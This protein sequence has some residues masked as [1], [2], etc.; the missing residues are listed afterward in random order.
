VVQCDMQMCV[1]QLLLQRVEGVLHRFLEGMVLLRMLCILGCSLPSHDGYVD[2]YIY[3]GRQCS[4]VANTRE[5]RKKG[6]EK[7]GN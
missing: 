6:V 7:R 3:L 2:G 1:L 4:G 5:R